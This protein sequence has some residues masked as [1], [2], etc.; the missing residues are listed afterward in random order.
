MI[1]TSS[2]SGVLAACQRGELPL[3]RRQP[4]DVALAIQPP[5]I[6][7]VRRRYPLVRMREIT[8]NRD[9]GCPQVVAGRTKLGEAI[10]FLGGFLLGDGRPPRLEGQSGRPTGRLGGRQTRGARVPSRRGARQ[11]T[12]DRGEHQHARM[13]Q[14]DRDPRQHR[15]GDADRCRR[16]DGDPEPGGVRRI[17]L[18]QR[19][20]DSRRRP[21]HRLPAGSCESW[22]GRPA[23]R[24]PTGSGRPVSWPSA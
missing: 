9:P 2:R 12:D 4:V 18:G 6:L 17:D 21:L 24:P 23:C 3:E 20:R 10:L 11:Q 15:A 19:D 1:W 22:P 8:W 5:R 16:G 7:K 14:S 13:A